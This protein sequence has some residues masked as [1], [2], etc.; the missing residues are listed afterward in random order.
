MHI[1]L[2][3][4]FAGNR[5]MVRASYHA[6][7]VRVHA[8][9]WS[10]RNIAKDFCTVESRNSSPPHV[11]LIVETSL[12]YGREV[13]RGISDYVVEHRPWSMY[14]DLRELI[15]EPP[16]WIDQWK[17]DGIISRST[18]PELAR[19]ITE[20]QNPDR[21]PHRYLRR[22]RSPPHLDR[23]SIKWENW[24]PPICSNVAFA[25]LDIAVSP[26]TIGPRVGSWDFVRHYEKPI[27]RSMFWNLLGRR[28]K[29]NRGKIS[30][31]PSPNGFPGCRARW[32]SSLVTTCAVSMSSMPADEL[33]PRSRK[34]LP[35]LVWTMTISS[36]GCANLPY[37]Q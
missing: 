23:Q 25:I 34:K 7:I 31:V 6:R 17:G 8:R 22:R 2:E 24:A 37:L 27:A 26:V 3:I 12:A 29:R 15:V 28:H 33:M 9:F 13:L 16:K 30:S 20:A 10:L 1:C 21:R 18:T 35:S 19:A 4:Y 36:V 32:V 5:P 11:M 14:L